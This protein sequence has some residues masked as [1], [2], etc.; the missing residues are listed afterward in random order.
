MSWY[1]RKMKTEESAAFIAFL[2]AWVKDVPVAERYRWLYQG[3][4]HGKAQIW[5]AVDDKTE[6]IVACKACFPKRMRLNG[7]VLLGCVGGDM[8][9]DPQWRRKG[10][11]AALHLRTKMEMKD[12]G[13]SLQYGFP[14]P[15]NF[16]A[17]LKTGARHPGN[18]FSAGLH[19]SSQP[20][21]R[22]V[23]LGRLIPQKLQRVLDLAMVR[24]LGL[25]PTRATEKR[26]IIRQITSFDHTFEAVEEEISSSF[27]ICCVHDMSYLQWRFFENP[28]KTC[29]VLGLEGIDGKLRG[30]GA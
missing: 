22:K 3:N 9:V 2:S 17:D 10:I 20:L 1:I 24:V 18:F 16:G 7:K 26:C 11:A 30:Y 15:E 19:L 13:I 6:E 8:Y 5:L 23:K 29:T 21:L 28:F 4:P 25:V 12:L 27:S 14:L